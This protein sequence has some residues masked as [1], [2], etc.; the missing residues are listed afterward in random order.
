MRLTLYQND[1]AREPCERRQADAL[2][3]ASGVHRAARHGRRAAAAVSRN[4][5]AWEKAGRWGPAELLHVA[6]VIAQWLRNYS[7]EMHDES[8]Q[9][10]LL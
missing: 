3:G 8:A 9:G 10:R 4:G 6:A 1:W 7:V 2:Q 5:T